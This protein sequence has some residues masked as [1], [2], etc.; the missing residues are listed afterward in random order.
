[1]ITICRKC[2]S[3]KILI[4]LFT[5]YFLIFTLLSILFIFNFFLFTLC[6]N[7]LVSTKNH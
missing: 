6:G 7:S 1:M 3:R 2:L 5:Y 4:I